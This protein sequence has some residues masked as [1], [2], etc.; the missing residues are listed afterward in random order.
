MNTVHG[1]IWIDDSKFVIDELE[2]LNRNPGPFQGK[3][4]LDRIGMLGS[5]FGG[6][7]AVEMTRI[8]SR[9]KAAVNHDGAL[10]VGDARAAGT[11]RPF[12][13]MRSD[14]QPDRDAPPTAEFDGPDITAVFSAWDSTAMAKSRGGAYYVEIARAHHLSFVDHPLLFRWDATRLPGKR[15]HEVIAAYTLGFLEQYLKGKDSPLLDGPPTDYPEV[16]RF[17]YR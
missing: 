4:D 9:V 15:G 7:V 11:N 10:Y 16:R 14:R 17:L 3:L 5:S 13:L 2:R 6:A 12:M 8:D 1:A